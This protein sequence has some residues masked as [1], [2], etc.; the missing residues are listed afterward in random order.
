MRGTLSAIDQG[1][2]MTD[3]M[4]FAQQ[5][6]AFT[7]PFQFRNQAKCRDGVIFKAPAPT[8][9]FMNFSAPPPSFPLAP[10]S[11]TILVSP[12]ERQESLLL[13]F[14]GY[15]ITLSTSGR[16]I[17]LE[18][19]LPQSPLAPYMQG[20]YHMKIW[21]CL[22]RLFYQPCPRAGTGKTL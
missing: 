11:T 4:Y 13:L 7:L 2:L 18:I 17:F 6:C 5:S 3:L 1:C 20:I 19:H 22:T 10:G 21:N 12:R 9:Q 16:V 8:V 15:S 14:I